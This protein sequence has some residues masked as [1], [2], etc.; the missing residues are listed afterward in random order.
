MKCKIDG[1]FIDTICKNKAEYLFLVALISSDNI[2]S[3]ED[4]EKSLEVID[5]VEEALKTATISDKKKQEFET[6]IEKGR[7]ILKDDIEY[8]NK[9]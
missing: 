9:K 3:K 2:V 6:Y 4:A 5:E 1:K 8:F 7:S